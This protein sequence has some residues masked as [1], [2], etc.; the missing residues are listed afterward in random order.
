MRA[1]IHRYLEHLEGERNVSPETLRA[2]E[3]DLL[4]FHLFLSRDFLGVDPETVR[5]KDVDALAVRSFLASMTR[6]GLAKSS[7]GRALAAVRSLFRFACREGSLAAN[8][9]QGVKTPKVPKTLP[10]HLR[11]G[12]VENLLEAPSVDRDKRGDKPLGRRDQAILELLYAAGLR[13]SELV[14][15]DWRDIDLS[16]RVLRVM[17][18]GRKERMVPFGR[19]AGEALRHWLEVW[20]G[21]RAQAGVLDDE[22]PVFLNRYGGRLTDRSVRNILDRWVESAAVAKGVHPHTMRHTFATH[23]L[24]NGADL[25]TIQELLGHSS[26]STTQKYTHLEVERLLLVY[27]EAHPRARKSSAAE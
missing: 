24:E 22:D 9:A 20:E 26:L 19:P 8:P 18:K 14:G 17:G 25:R 23:L 3:R 13:V 7:Q 4:R 11:P 16:A 12:E 6:E 21:I 15:L 1:L 2:Y 5:P 27:R 10:R